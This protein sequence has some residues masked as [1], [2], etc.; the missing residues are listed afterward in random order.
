MN[1]AN[2]KRN[3]FISNVVNIVNYSIWELKLQKN[4]IPVNTFHENLKIAIRKL[5]KFNQIRDATRDNNYFI[6]RVLPG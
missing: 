6:C 3:L 2:D 1:V 5:L 4:L